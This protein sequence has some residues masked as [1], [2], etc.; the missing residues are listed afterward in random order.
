[1]QTVIA[2]TSAQGEED[3][4]FLI[5]TLTARFILAFS[6]EEIFRCWSTTNLEL[7]AAF[8]TWARP[9]MVC[10]SS[11]TIVI[12]IEGF[13]LLYFLRS[14]S[15]VRQPAPFPSWGAK[16]QYMDPQGYLYIWEP[17]IQAIQVY[18]INEVL[19]SIHFTSPISGISRF[20]W[21]RTSSESAAAIA[22]ILIDG[23]LDAFNWLPWSATDND[24]GD[25]ATFG[26]EQ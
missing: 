23:G 4:A 12:L 2:S 17:E 9:E 22:S 11:G 24:I 14:Q 16:S 18:Q 10:A 20:S 26:R 8:T 13:W 19:F 5:V 6:E 21:P 1:M 7:Q 25:A 3:E 15:S